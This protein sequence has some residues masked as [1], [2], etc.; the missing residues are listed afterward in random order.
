MK[1]KLDYFRTFF[2]LF[3]FS[4]IEFG[5]SI[6]VPRAAFMQICPRFF[7]GVSGT[8]EPE[9]QQPAGDDGQ[10]NDSSCKLVVGSGEVPYRQ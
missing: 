4:E 5:S 8:S 2:Y 6:K 9:R 3:S 10:S 1:F 7:V